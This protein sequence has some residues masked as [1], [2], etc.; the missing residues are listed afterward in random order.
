MAMG[1]NETDDD[2][3]DVR[4]QKRQNADCWT[5]TI[6]LQVQILITWEF[7]GKQLWKC[8]LAA[9]IIFLVQNC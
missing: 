9:S 1:Q 3:D 4:S 7:H 6:G 2:D 5:N 8:R